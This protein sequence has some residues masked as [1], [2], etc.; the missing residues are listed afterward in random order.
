MK[1]QN[2]QYRE[3]ARAIFEKAP[4]AADLGIVLSDLGPGWCETVLTVA[5][6]HRQQDGYVHAGVQA[7][8][9]D[10]TAGGAAGTLVRAGELVLTAEYKINFLRPAVGE[11]LR[12]RATVLKPGRT[13]IVAESEVYS[14]R[15]GEEKMVAK[16]M[17]TLAPVQPETPASPTAPATG[18]ASGT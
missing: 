8:M 14:V 9:A 17:V 18:G 12:C 3:H 13:L 16:A 4:F 6:K 11:R 1:P 10:H 5:P 15:D 2:P 7:T